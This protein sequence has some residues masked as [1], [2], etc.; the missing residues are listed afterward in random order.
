MINSVLIQRE[1][2][3]HIW[4]YNSQTWAVKAFEECCALA[5]CTEQ[6]E[7]Q[8]FTDTFEHYSYDI[9]NHCN[10]SI[11]TGMLKGVNNKTKV[12]KHKA[13]YHD[14]RC[15]SPKSYKLSSTNWEMIHIYL[16]TAVGQNCLLV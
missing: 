1:K 14:L 2:F 8:N 10:Y 13:Y 9:L 3:K 11:H 5:Q 4:T 6:P 7:V 16:F 12:I 15:L